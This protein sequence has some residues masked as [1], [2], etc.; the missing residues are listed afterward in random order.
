MNCKENET[1]IMN[2][3]CFKD[4]YDFV[5][6]SRYFKDAMHLFIGGIVLSSYGVVGWWSGEMLANHR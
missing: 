4:D 5:G 2:S 3:I 1:K 6:R